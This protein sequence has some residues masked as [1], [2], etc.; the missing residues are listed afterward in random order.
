MKPEMLEVKLRQFMKPGMPYYLQE[1][2]IGI[3]MELIWKP[4]TLERNARDVK[5]VY[6][7]R[8]DNHKVYFIDPLPVDPCK[9]AKWHDKMVAFMNQSYF[10]N[11]RR[12]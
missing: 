7:R 5:S 9:Y 2:V 3:G 12:K 6:F 4:E 1:L 11:L 10:I 8:I